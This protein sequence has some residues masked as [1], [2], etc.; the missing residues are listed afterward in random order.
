VLPVKEG[1]VV[2]ADNTEEWKRG[3]T[4][5]GLGAPLLVTA[6]VTVVTGG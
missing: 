4:L 2:T 5:V 3:K 6:V 1:V